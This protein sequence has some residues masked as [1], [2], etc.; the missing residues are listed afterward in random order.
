MNVGLTATSAN[1]SGE[2]ECI[3]AMAVRDQLGMRIPII[4]D[5]GTSPREIPSTIVDLTDEDARWKIQNRAEN[6]DSAACAAGS[7]ARTSAGADTAVCEKLRT[8]RGRQIELATDEQGDRRTLY[9]IK[10][11]QRLAGAPG[12]TD[13]E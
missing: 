10:E 4:V 1:L 13:G 7:E 6:G 2:S 12:G 3:T 9:L 5:G 8:I 11:V